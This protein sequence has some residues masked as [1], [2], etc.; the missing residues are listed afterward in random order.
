MMVLLT[1]I[2]FSPQAQT[3][4]TIGTATS[5]SFHSPVY[6]SSTS[7][8]FRYSQT[9]SL[10]TPAEINMAGNLISLAWE[11]ADATGY[12]HGDAMFRIYVK[13]TTAS[14][15]ATT[16]GTFATE[17]TGATL[18]Y[19]SFTQSLPTAPGWVL[20]N[21]TTPFAYSGTSNL[22]VMV[23]WDRPDVPTANNPLWYYTNT[24]G[25]AATWSGSSTP[26]TSSYGSGYTRANIQMTFAPSAALDAGIA[27]INA[28]QT[29]FL[30]GNNNVE[31]TIRNFGTSNLTS[32]TINWMV[33]GMAQTPYNWTGN[34]ASASI[35]SAVVIGTYNFPLGTHEITAWTSAPNGGVDSATFNDTASVSV[36]CIVPL[37]GTYTIG[38]SSPDYATFADALTDLDA[39]GISGPVTFNVA[40][41]TYNERVTLPEVMGADANNRVTFQSATGNAADVVI[42]APVSGTSDN[43]V[44]KFDGADYIT[45]QNLTL[46]IDTPYTSYGRVVVY[47]GGANHN[48]L[49][50]NV[51]ESI[52][53]TGSSTNYATVYSENSQDEYN[54]ISHNTIRKGTYGIR[55]YSP[56][57]TTLE[58][59]NIIESNTIDGY[60]Y[61]G[62]YMYG[63]DAPIV[64]KNTLTNAANSGI[65][66]GIYMWYCDNMMQVTKN[67]ME[68]SGSSTQYGIRLSYCDAVMGMEGLVA[69]NFIAQTSGASLTTY[70]I[71]LNYNTFQNIYFNSVNVLSTGTSAYGLYVTTGN[72]NIDFT[73]NI[74]SMPGGGRV[75]YATT[76]TISGISAMNNN[77]YYTTGANFA[78]GGTNVTTLADWQT[79]SLMD[80][81]SVVADPGYATPAL[82]Y[83]TSA[84][85]DNMAVPI[86]MVP[87]DIDGNIRSLTTPD[88]GAAEFTPPTNDMAVLSWDNPL[89]SSC[90]LSATES[91]T[92]TLYNNGL[93]AQTGTEVSYSIDGGTTWSTPE[94]IGNPIPAGDTL[95]YT[96]NALANMSAIGVYHC[97]A[98]VNAPGDANS[99]NDSISGI[100]VTNIGL[101]N[102]PFMEDFA[103]GNTA[104]FGLEAQ[105][106]ALIEVNSLQGNAVPAL[107][108]TGGSATGF[109]GGS[110]SA[111]P[112]Q[113]WIDNTTHHASAKTCLIDGSG[114]TSLKLSFDLKMEY[115]YGWAYSWFR[116]LVN[117]TIQLTDLNGVSNFNP[118]TA[119]A[120]P[121]TLVEFDL[122]PYL[123]QPFTITLQSS[124]KYAVGTGSQNGDNAYVDNFQIY[125]P[126]PNDVGINA[127]L[128]PVDSACASAATDVVV[129]L[130]NFGG[131]IQDSVPVVVEVIF[132]DASTQ[133]LSA[134]YTD[135]LLA[136][137]S[138]M[139]VVGS[140]STLMS[141]TYQ[142]TAYTEL[143]G[144]INNMNDTATG[145]FIT[146]QPINIFPHT[147]DFESFTTGAPGTFAN[148]WTTD[149]S[150]GFRWQVQSGTTSSTNTGPAV[151]HTTGTATGIYVYTEASSGSQGNEAFLTSPCLDLA[152][153]AAPE[154]RFWYHMYG[155]DIDK[156]AVE[157]LFGGVWTE[158]Y[159][160]IGPQ[161]TA[162]ADPWLEAVVSLTN[163]SGADRVR[164]KV[165]RGPSF[166]GDVSIDDVTF[167]EAPQFEAAL[168]EAYGLTS[169]CN[170]TTDQLTIKI[171]NRGGQTINGNLNASYMVH[172]AATAVT[173]AVTDSIAVGDTLEFTFAAP[174]NLLTAMDSMF[175][176]TAWIDLLNDPDPSNDTA[177]TSVN[178]LVSPMDPMV[179]NVSITAGSQA[180]LSVINPDPNQVYFWYDS[181]MATQELGVG[182]TFLTP[183]LTATTVYYV[184]AQWG[185]PASTTALGPG[186]ATNSWIP[187][188][189]YYD[190]SW[191]KS[192]YTAAELNFF[193]QV[194]TLSYFVSN[195]PSPNPYVMPGQK[196]WMGHTADLEFGDNNYMD[197][198]LMTKVFEGTISWSGPGEVKI[199]LDQS[200][201]YNGSDNMVI[202]VENWDGDWLSGQPVFVANSITSN[203]AVYQYQDNTF[204][205]TAGSSATTKPDI[206]LS[207]SFILLG[208]G[209]PSNRVA[210][211]VFVTAPSV[212]AMA[213]NDTT[214]CLGDSAQLNVNVT[215][216]QA[217]YTYAWSPVGSL[218]NAAVANPTAGPVVTT[219]YSV[220]VTDQNGDS[221]TDDVIVTVDPGPNVTLS[222]FANVCLQS[223]AFTL[224]G[225]SPAG[226]VY[227][228][229]GVSGG[230]FD[231]AIADTGVHTI[232]YTFTDPLSGCSGYAM[233][234]IYVDPCVGLDEMGTNADLSVYPNPASEMVQLTFR[235]TEA[236]VQLSLM[237]LTGKLIWESNILNSSGQMS[238]TLDISN[239]P[240]GIYYVRLQD[241]VHIKA[242]KLIK[243]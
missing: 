69:N 60:A 217:P 193:G 221:G 181:L 141:G 48:I 211:T 26:P 130:R 232:T 147:E 31:V 2:A 88:P 52:A 94:I 98:A 49:T 142:L 133:T 63:Q 92:I 205:Y 11:K 167:Q 25:L 219:T 150:T 228:G 180:T 171:H 42:Q 230:M 79:F 86:A 119:T 208:N 218:N 241:G 109:A 107:F 67:R 73:N 58:M 139:F 131:V 104:Y 14:S 43:W 177:M 99:L 84:G 53:A 24:P 137:S 118:T 75:A 200:F 64:T 12:I 162:Q 68:L 76:T 87:D 197:T 77:A 233:E 96:F 89:G 46:K 28:P 74:V 149:P 30:P 206:A 135:S 47:D 50:G 159:S 106:E 184:E 227:S 51:I 8:S 29:P 146:I 15:V 95:V 120:D 165:T 224:T 183:A 231:P 144:D 204:P 201:V 188:Y 19:E 36:I 145:S 10:F 214:I 196:I 124:M 81:N 91:V 20:F 194:D 82:L 161:Q 71:Y 213:S 229:P 225:G 90:G 44:W 1:L 32:A 236:E 163:Y 16:S 212:I 97:M 123:A 33:N 114:F 17:L 102:L 21:L 199:A 111:T 202:Y 27:A 113:A 237:D 39:G 59:G 129:D 61:Y 34:L 170:L 223:P 168:L 40:S 23:D 4:V 66:Y 209:C 207:G 210:D 132:P 140:F 110:T 127:I 169:G 182:D 6:I 198:T 203:Q 121:F 93:S 226:G 156:L 151:D 175:V 80:M 158:V 54:I 22:M 65:V 38:G 186:S 166:D 85:V 128:H 174:I 178:S 134:V 185:A 126:L 78:Y 164:F 160:L 45:V 138:D 55:M 238:E 154:M 122:T 7:S 103:T 116:V 189:G 70:P 222:P 72:N 13:E 234:T 190:Y 100:T 191:S 5:T 153:M 101:M 157:V 148:G 105:P 235:S 176:V 220:T 216:G 117:D 37:N 18:V 155:V 56:N 179:A 41:G 57:S 83:P 115:S 152:Q 3:T 239:L 9:I 125:E 35:D 187:V 172:G 242:V 240:Q 173:E 243:H 136:N 112:T 215:G 62:I 192:L 143:P 195:V 108:F